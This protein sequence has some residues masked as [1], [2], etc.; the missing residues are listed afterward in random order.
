[1][2][3][4]TEKNVGDVSKPLVTQTAVLFGLEKHPTQTAQPR[5]TLL[6]IGL[7]FLTFYHWK[8]NPTRIRS[9]TPPQ[10][11]MVVEDTM[12]LI[13]TRAFPHRALATLPTAI[14][15]RVTSR[16]GVVG[17][18]TKRFS[19]VD[20]SSLGDGSRPLNPTCSRRGQ[21]AV[22]LLTEKQSD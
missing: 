9:R 2:S 15:S 11:D 17:S 12:R 4:T 1:M 22:K 16:S 8:K 13:A 10:N 6:P 19:S 3:T 14:P 21:E 5:Q 20:S 7:K 18:P